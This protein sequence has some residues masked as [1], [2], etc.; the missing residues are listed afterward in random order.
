MFLNM[1]YGLAGAGAAA[2]IHMHWGGGRGWVVHLART[3]WRFSLREGVAALELIMNDRR[4]KKA[5]EVRG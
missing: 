4:R 2:G 3:A 1:W 5:W